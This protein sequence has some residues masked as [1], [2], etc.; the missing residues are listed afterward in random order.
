MNDRRV[1][2]LL[3]LLRQHAEEELSLAVMALG[4][5]FT[6]EMRRALELRR[7]ELKARSGA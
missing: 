4:P 5:S 2:H 6:P 1:A 3:E 7:L